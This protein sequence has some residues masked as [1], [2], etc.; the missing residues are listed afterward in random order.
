M[1]TEM[2]LSTITGVT[3][4]SL[5]A[6]SDTDLLDAETYLMTKWGL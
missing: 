5:A 1:G 2:I 6:L 3:V 4:A